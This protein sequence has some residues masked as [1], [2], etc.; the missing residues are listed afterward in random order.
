MITLEK[1]RNVWIASIIFVEL[2]IAACCSITV[3]Y[4]FGH[5]TT[6]ENAIIHIISG[7]MGWFIF[8][9]GKSKTIRRWIVNNYTIMALFGIIIDG[10]TELCL[11]ISPFVKMLCD[12]IALSSF[13]KFYHI[14]M[15]ER[16]N[17]IFDA[18]GRVKF[19]LDIQRAGAIG[20]VVG[21]LLALLSPKIDIEYVIWISTIWTALTY[22]TSWYRFQLCDRYMKQEGIIPPCMQDS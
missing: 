2:Q 3:V 21:G 5:M 18:D 10:G 4:A 11:L 14:Q 1:V 16:L 22:I 13:F 19:D 20:V 7:L 17:V 9:V 15:V 8:T 12:V 6:D